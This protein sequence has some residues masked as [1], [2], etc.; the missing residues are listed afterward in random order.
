MN[1]TY[2]TGVGLLS[3]L[4]DSFSSWPEIICVPDKKT[5]TIKPILRVIFSRDG[6]LIL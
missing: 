5:S 1:H 6:I 2:I 3:I 4:V